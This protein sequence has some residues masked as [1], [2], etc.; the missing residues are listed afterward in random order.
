M[1]SRQ[2]RQAP[3]PRALG[4]PTRVWIVPFVVIA[5]LAAVYFAVS[6]G[7]SSG[8]FIP[9]EGSTRRGESTDTSSRLSAEVGVPGISTVAESSARS[10]HES[11]RPTTA[12]AVLDERARGEALLREYAQLVGSSSTIK[13]R[14]QILEEL[15]AFADKEL[16]RRMIYDAMNF[17]GKANDSLVMGHHAGMVLSRLHAGNLSA[18]LSRRGDLFAPI[19]PRAKHAVM[20]EILTSLGPHPQKELARSFGDDLANAFRFAEEPELRWNIVNNIAR[21][22]DPEVCVSVFEESLARPI[23][24][25]RMEILNTIGAMARAAALHVESR[26]RYAGLLM[27]TVERGDLDVMVA[28]EAVRLLREIAPDQ[29]SALATRATASDPDVLAVLRAASG[30][31]K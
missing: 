16:A 12:P 19:G 28:K 31:D 23:A 26:G 20:A 3:E 18:A 5:A 10:K 13:Q 6:Q 4:S 9:N 15:A 7:T 2:N 17:E 27:A 25:D 1:N 14:D 30:S 11:E 24:T 22:A 29:L 8:E 21:I